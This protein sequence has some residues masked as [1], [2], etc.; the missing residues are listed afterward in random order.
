MGSNRKDRG[1]EVTDK[2]F[3]CTRC[4]DC[5]PG[6]E[7]AKILARQAIACGLR[8]VVPHLLYTQFLDDSQPTERT[9]GLAS[10]SDDLRECSQV[11]LDSSLSISPGMQ[12]DIMLALLCDIPIHVFAV[13]RPG[14]TPQAITVLSTT[15]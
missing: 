8:P 4:G 15:E 9:Q 12:G 7:H 13:I 14:D 3:I 1:V 11:W 6:I 2:V 5:A 10:G